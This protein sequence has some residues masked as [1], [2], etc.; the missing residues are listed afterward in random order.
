MTN[1]QFVGGQGVDGVTH[2]IPKIYSRLPATPILNL[3]LA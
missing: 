3:F 1:E 2:S